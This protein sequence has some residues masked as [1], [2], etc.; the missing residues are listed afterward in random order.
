MGRNRWLQI[1][2][3]FTADLKALIDIIC[4]KSQ[5]FYIPSSHVSID[6][7]LIPFKGI[8]YNYLKKIYFDIFIVII[9][10]RYKYR[11]HIRGKPKATGLKV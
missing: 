7:S 2:R 9:L 3:F 5:K 1:Y 6:E 8:Y 4:K 11:Q 10:E